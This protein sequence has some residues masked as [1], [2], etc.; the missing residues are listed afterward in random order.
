MEGGRQAHASHWSAWVC[1]KSTG[2]C[3]A[4]ILQLKLELVRN[5]DSKTWSFVNPFTATR[6]TSFFEEMWRK[7]IFEK[8][9]S[10]MSKK[11]VCSLLLCLLLGTYCAADFTLLWTGMCNKMWRCVMSVQLRDSF[12]CWTGRRERKT[13]AIVLPLSIPSHLAA[14]PGKDRAQKEPTETMAAPGPAI[15]S[16]WCFS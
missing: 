10:E 1:F 14:D 16:R 6:L 9:G 7:L 13:V 12:P 8:G 3:F 5:W 2:L 15:P 4:F 11:A